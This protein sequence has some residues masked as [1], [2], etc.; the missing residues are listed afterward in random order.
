MRGRTRLIVRSAL[1]VVVIALGLVH[2]RHRF[3][4]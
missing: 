1:I 3:D 2:G 4:P